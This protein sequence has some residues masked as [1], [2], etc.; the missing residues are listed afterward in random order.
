MQQ[1]LWLVSL[2]GDQRRISVTAAGQVEVRP[3]N[4]VFGPHRMLSP[5]WLFRRPTRLTQAGSQVAAL[6]GG[7]V[8]G[9]VRADGGAADARAAAAIAAQ[10][11]RGLGFAHRLMAAVADTV[12]YD[13]DGT[14]PATTAEEALAR[15]SGVCQDHAHI[16]AAAPR[17]AGIPERYVSGY[18]RMEDREEEAATHAWAELRLKGLGWVGFDAANRTGPNER[19][20]RIANG[21]DYD[22][23]APIG[24]ICYGSTG[25]FLDVQLHVAE[26]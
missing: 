6:V 14:H 9:L 5:L 15:G 11:D 21:R 2:R 22:E 4:R 3:S 12:R 20:V 23:A 8:E 7:L 19:Y 18:L 16:M 13:T 1:C 10:G 24:G 17:L 25:E 26:Q